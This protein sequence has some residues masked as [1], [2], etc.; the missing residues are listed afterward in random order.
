MKL[1]SS[2]RAY[3]DSSYFADFV[4]D[5]DLDT[6]RYVQKLKQRISVL[7]FE[8]IIPQ[9]VLGEIMSKV[10]SSRGQKSSKSIPDMI[11]TI[12]FE[13]QY[14]V[15]PDNCLP[16]IKP[17]IIPHFCYLSERC[18][19]EPTDAFILSYALDDRLA[20]YFIT[21]DKKIIN[22]NGIEFY[23]E[24]LRN[25]DKRDFDLIITDSP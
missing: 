25:E 17:E 21:K 1:V 20:R 15:N 18:S 22:N 10:L 12:I 2:E 24:C 8:I 6:K 19:L 3:L 4:F 16:P 9:T 14:F 7:H 5:E 11:N 23:Q 13:I